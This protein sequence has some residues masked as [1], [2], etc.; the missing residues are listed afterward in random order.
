MHVDVVVSS[1]RVGVVEHTPRST[2]L[3]RPCQ[4][5]IQSHEHHQTATDD[6]TT[7][8]TSS[9]GNTTQHTQNTRT[10]KAHAHTNLRQAMDI[11]E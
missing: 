2:G 3:T 7:G 5:P 4:T 11:S 10:H 6:E 9:D 1:D 8:S